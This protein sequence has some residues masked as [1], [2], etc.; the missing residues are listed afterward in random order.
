[1]A[2]ERRPLGIEISVFDSSS[3]VTLAIS[4]PVN[5]QYA[6]GRVQKIPIVPPANHRGFGSAV[7]VEVGIDVGN[8][9]GMEVGIPVGC[10]VGL[11]LDKSLL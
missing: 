2:P 9:V 7:G 11:K 1:M 8:E 10:T 3:P 5:I 4:I 6:K